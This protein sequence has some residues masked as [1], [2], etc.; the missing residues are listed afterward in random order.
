MGDNEISITQGPSPPSKSCSI[1]RELAADAQPRSDEALFWPQHML[2]VPAPAIGV[3]LKFYMLSEATMLWRI[4][5]ECC[6]ANWYDSALCD[7]PD[8]CKVEAEKVVGSAADR[9]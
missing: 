7:R 9:F 6:N 5:Q 3:L 8:L 4:T 2:H 1:S